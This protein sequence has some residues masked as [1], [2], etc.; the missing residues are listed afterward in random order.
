MVEP[1]NY[2]DGLFNCVVMVWFIFRLHITI[3]SL[4]EPRSLAGVVNYFGYGIE[5]RYVR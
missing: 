1:I 4:G 5:N 2:S 3:I